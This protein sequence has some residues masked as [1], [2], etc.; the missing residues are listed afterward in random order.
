MTNTFEIVP[1]YN[2]LSTFKTHFRLSAAQVQYGA[3]DVFF[4]MCLYSRYLFKNIKDNV[5]Y[6]FYK[7]CRD[8]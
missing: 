6:N 4:F 3:M 2:S 8:S 1:C 7:Y 5:T